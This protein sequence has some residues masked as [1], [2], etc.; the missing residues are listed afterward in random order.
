MHRSGTFAAVALAAAIAAAATPAVS[1]PMDPFM[2]QL[3]TDQA[4]NRAVQLYRAGDFEGARRA[5]EAY[6]G[7]NPTSARGHEI[8]GAILGREGDLQGSLAALDAAVRLAPDLATVHANRAVVLV[9]LG[10][11]DEAEAALRTATEVDPTLLEAQARLGLLLEAK[12]DFDGALERYEIFATG[13][14]GSNPGVRVNLAAIYNARGRFE[15]TIALL[16]LWQRDR[17]VDPRLHSLLADAFLGSGRGDTALRQ[18]RFALEVG[19]DDDPRAS[20]GLGIAHRRLGEFDDAEQVFEDLIARF[21]DSPAPHAQMAELRIAQEDFAA[22]RASFETAIGLSAAPQEIERRLASILVAR[23]E[24]DDA[25]A[26]YDA[27]IERDGPSAQLL[28]ERARAFAAAGRLDDAQAELERGVELH[29]E[30]P[31]TWIALSLLHRQR[32]DFAAALRVSEAGLSRHTGNQPLLRIAATSARDV[33]EL[34]KALAYGQQIL[35][36][37]PNDLND[38][39]I[40]ATLLDKARADRQAIALYREVA[41]AQRN[42]WAA[43]NNLALVL[44]RN[45]NEKEALVYARRAGQMQPDNPAVK[46]TLAW[47]LFRNGRIGEAER[48]MAEAAAALPD[49]AEVRIHYGMILHA[50]GRMEDARRELSAGIRLNPD[51]EK[52]PAARDLLDSL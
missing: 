30:T 18:Y 3:Q 8:L 20:L 25:V 16:T 33:D 52:A 22:A 47:V 2:E 46:H 27:M 45:A 42:N 48:M 34:R 9:E 35:E 11:L 15:D 21:P 14:E 6:I 43:M 24:I 26:I 7:F 28:V 40:F 19:P 41:D 1:A 29:P 23:G 4:L 50:R 36:Q 5:V 39:F 32:T 17:D 13:P 44:E 31:Q 37:N 49:E 12:G 10:R 51:H 38:K